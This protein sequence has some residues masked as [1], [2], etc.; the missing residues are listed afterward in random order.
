MKKRSVAAA[1]LDSTQANDDAASQ[2]AK[3]RFVT[4]LARVAFLLAEF[5]CFTPHTGCYQRVVKWSS[6]LIVKRH[7]YDKVFSELNKRFVSS[8]G[9]HTAITKNSRRARAHMHAAQTLHC[10]VSES[11]IIIAIERNQVCLAFYCCFFQLSTL[12]C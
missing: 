1:E 7:P 3:K 4:K 12:R 2:E 6:L 8:C 9:V 11:I 5:F 10:K